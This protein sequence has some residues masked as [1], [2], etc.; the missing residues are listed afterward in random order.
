M[1][2]NLG[3]WDS[4]LPPIG[5]PTGTTLDAST[6]AGTSGINPADGPALEQAMS[7]A[8]NA[9]RDG[10]ARAT[11]VRLHAGVAP[12]DWAY[13]KWAPASYSRGDATAVE[14]Q[15]IQEALRQDVE[16]YDATIANYQEARQ[17]AADLLA[18]RT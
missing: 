18:V 9:T 16:W 8:F 15:R 5:I 11:L 10:L 6:I 7:M 14:W 3:A 1:S 17:V 13:T 12:D 4:S 2:A